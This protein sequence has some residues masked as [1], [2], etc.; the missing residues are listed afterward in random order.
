MRS[1]RS[2]TATTVATP[3]IFWISSM[4]PSAILPQPTMATLR[5]ISVRA[6]RP[7]GLGEGGL[8]GGEP[9]DGHAERRARHVVEAHPAEEVDRGR[10]AAVLAAHA[11]LH[12]RA[13]R[14][15]ALAG[16]LH[17]RAHARLV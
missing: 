16:H 5:V 7:L 8:R 1:S 9:G 13:R 10:I 14:A 12:P 2:A 3:G 4:W 15:A 6:L 17:Q 11:E